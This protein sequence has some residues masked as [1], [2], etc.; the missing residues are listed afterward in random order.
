[1]RRMEGVILLILHFSFSS[2]PSR[3]FD[4]HS[5]YYSYIIAT[6]RGTKTMAMMIEVSS[7]SSRRMTM[8]MMMMDFSLVL[9]LLLLSILLTLSQ[10]ELSMLMVVRRANS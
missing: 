2:S 1:M 6:A 10:D 7:R 8:M 4:R 5:S 3:L 9:L